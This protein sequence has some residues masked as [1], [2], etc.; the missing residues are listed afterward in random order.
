MVAIGDLKTVFILLVNMLRSAGSEVALFVVIISSEQ[1]S[2]GSS[3]LTVGEDICGTRAS[4][5]ALKAGG[6]LSRSL[7]DVG[8]LVW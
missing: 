1:S 2:A 7:T 4:S 5:E 3:K 6:R 8:P